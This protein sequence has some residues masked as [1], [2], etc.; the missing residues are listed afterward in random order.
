MY[1]LLA[2][3]REF[4]PDRVDDL[5]AYIPRELLVGLVAKEI[6]MSSMQELAKEKQLTLVQYKLQGLS[7][8]VYLH[9][10]E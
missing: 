8:S 10:F 3:I 2:A 4:R 7:N 6:K 9:L 1:N 5:Q